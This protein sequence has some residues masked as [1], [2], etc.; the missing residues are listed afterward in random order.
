MAFKKAIPIEANGTTPT[1][2]RVCGIY[3]DAAT[4][5]ARIVLIGY[6]SAEV[7]ARNAQGGIDQREYVLGPAQFAALAASHAKGVSTFDA[8]AGACYEFIANARR[9]CE[10]DPETGEGVLH[11]G[12]RFD[13]KLVQVLG[14]VPTIPSE[15]ADAVSV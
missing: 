13:S 11:S 14:D 6:V 9:P 15:F 2:W 12:E 4:A 1:Y 10:L 7:R 8:I 3:I 5:Q